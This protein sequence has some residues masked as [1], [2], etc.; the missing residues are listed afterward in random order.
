MRTTPGLLGRWSSS[1]LLRWSSSE[2]SERI[3]ETTLSTSA[4]RTNEA[5][6]AIAQSATGHTTKPITGHSTRQMAT[7]INA[8]RT[9]GDACS[10]GVHGRCFTFVA[11]LLHSPRTRRHRLSA[12]ASDARREHRRRQ[13]ALQPVEHVIDVELPERLLLLPQYADQIVRRAHQH[14]VRPTRHLL[15]V[16][17]AEHGDEQVRVHPGDHLRQRDRRVGH[18]RESSAPGSGVAGVVPEARSLR[19]D[20]EHSGGTHHDVVDVHPS[21]VRRVQAVQH[22]PPTRRQCRQRTSARRDPGHVFPPCSDAPGDRRV[23]T[24]P[25]PGNGRVV[26]RASPTSAARAPSPCVPDRR[27]GDRC[28]AGHSVHRRGTSPTAGPRRVRR[29]RALPRRHP[30]RVAAR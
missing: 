22:P 10:P 4:Q 9:A 3:V 11:L 27:A 5:S 28:A 19:G 15:V 25:C 30:R 8:D 12:S 7:A 26:R 20:H 23:A 16:R 17:G 13:R 14:T 2:R 21:V 29:T 18:T 6:I 24:R 1:E